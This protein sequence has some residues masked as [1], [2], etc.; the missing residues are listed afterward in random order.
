ML[1]KFVHP[2]LG[3]PLVVAGHVVAD[4]ARREGHELAISVDSLDP[5]GVVVDMLGK[6]VHPNIGDPLVVAGHVVAD[7]ARR[8]GHMNLQ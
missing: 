6:F 2:N 8:E 1:G 7:A 4:A 5:Y 3:D